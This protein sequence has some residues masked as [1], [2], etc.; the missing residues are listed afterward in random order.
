VRVPALL[1]RAG[2]AAAGLPQSALDATSKRSG[3]AWGTA[4]KR[5]LDLRDTVKKREEDLRASAIAPLPL[6]SFGPPALRRL[7][8]EGSDEDGTLTLAGA[9][10]LAAK[11][12]RRLSADELSPTDR[13]DLGCAYAVLAWVERCDEHWLCAIEELRAARDDSEAGSDIKAKARKNLGAIRDASGFDIE[14]IAG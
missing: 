9:R 12:I 4:K 6:P 7:E 14:G 3:Q 10:M 11:T 13:N 1:Q 2:T 8:W 5:G